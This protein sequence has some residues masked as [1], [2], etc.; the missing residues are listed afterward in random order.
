MVTLYPYGAGVS[1]QVQSKLSH[2]QRAI[3][4]GGYWGGR[5]KAPLLIPAGGIN[6]VAWMSGMRCRA[7]PQRM[8][9]AGWRWLAGRLWA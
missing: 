1:L 5:L 8:G 3:T 7:R 6:S 4:R 9:R 2:C